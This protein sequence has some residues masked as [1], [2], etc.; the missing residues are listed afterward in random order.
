VADKP[1]GLG[2]DGRMTGVVGCS[3]AVEVVID[4]GVCGS[5]LVTAAPTTKHVARV[6]PVPERQ[7]RDA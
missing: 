6:C 3:S 1:G 7:H 5:D 4:A 2:A